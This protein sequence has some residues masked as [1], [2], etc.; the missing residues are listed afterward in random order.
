[1]LSFQNYITEQY[2]EE[3]LILYSQGK[4]GGEAR[5]ANESSK[6]DSDKVQTSKNKFDT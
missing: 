4:K 3:K 2:L 6:S 1:M 5:T